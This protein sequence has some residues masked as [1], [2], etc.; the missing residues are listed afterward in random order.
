MKIYLPGPT[1]L[2]RDLKY[3]EVAFSGLILNRI[4]FFLIRSMLVLLMLFIVFRADALSSS[5]PSVMIKGKKYIPEGSQPE[6]ENFAEPVLVIKNPR[7]SVTLNTSSSSFSSSGEEIQFNIEVRNTG[8][9]DISQIAV[10]DLLTGFEETIALLSPRDLRNFSTS[11][12]TTQ[13]DLEAGGITN[14]VTA[15]GLDPENDEVSAD[16]TASVTAAS[17]PQMEP[18]LEVIKTASPVTYSTPGDVISFSIV[19][20][21]TGNVTLTDISVEDPLIGL[22]QIITTLDPESQ[23]E[24]TGNY[25]VTQADLNNGSITNTATASGTDAGNN[26]VDAEDS[27]TVTAV[28]DPEL[29][30]TKSASTATFSSVGERITYTITV[31]NT[32]NVTITNIAVDDPL[33][34]LSENIPSLTPGAVDEYTALYDVTQADL[35]KGNIINTVTVSGT[36]TENNPVTDDATVTVNAVFEPGLNVTNTASAATFSSVGETITYTISV[37]NTGNVTITN[38][39][40]SDL[41]TGLNENIVSLAPGADEDYTALYVV[42]QADLNNGTIV[43]TVTASG[44][45]PEN[46]TISETGTATVTAALNP[47]LTLTKT[48]S[49]EVFSSVGEVITYTIAVENTGNVTLTGIT[50]SDPLTGMNRTIASMAP[51]VKQEYTENYIVKQADL[52]QGSIV[53]K[54]TASGSDPENNTVTDDDE[55]TVNASLTPGLSLT[56][57]ASPSTFSSVGEDITYTIVVENTGNV[58][59]TG[60]TV[61]DP[62]TGMNNTIASLAPGEEQDY[63]E[64]YKVTQADLNTGSIVNTAT[65]SGKDPENNTVTDDDEVTINAS[66]TTGLSLTKSASPE[67]FSSVGEVITYSIVVENT[68]NVTISTITVSDPLTGMNRNIASLAPG[69]KADFTETYNITQADINSGSVTNTATASGQDPGGQTVNTTGSATVTAVLN[70]SLSIS[71]NASSESFSSAGDIITYTISVENTGNITLSNITVTDPLTAMNQTIATLAPGNVRIF[72]QTYT[73]T[74]ADVNEGSITNTAT[75][76]VGNITE[77]ASVTVTAEQNPQLNVSKSASPATFGTVGDEITFVIGVENTG[78]TTIS[79]IRVTDPM[80]GM[81]ETIG[82]L[83]PGASRNFTETYAVRQTD[84]DAGSISNTVTASSNTVSETATATATASQNPVLS[85]SKVASQESYSSVGEEISY[86]IIVLN[87]GNVTLTGIRVEDPLTGMNETINSLAPGASRTFNETFIVTAAVITAGKITNTVNVSGLAPDNS[88]VNAIAVAE[89]TALNPPVANDDASADHTSGDIV[90]VNILANDLLHDGSPA[91]PALVTVDIN[92][93]SPG[94]QDE[95]VVTGTGTWK[96]NPSTG[97]LTFTPV[98][99]FTTDPDPIEY[100]L[101]EKLTGLSDRAT[102]TVD[103]NEGEPFAINDNSSGHQPGSAVTINILANDRLSDGSQATTGTVSIDLNLQAEGIQTEF[104]R[105]GEGTWSYN[106]STGE[107][108]FVPQPGFTT[109]PTPLIYI[110]IENLTE[111][112]DQAIITLGYEEQ[113]PVAADDVSSGNNPGDSVSI[114]ILANDKLSDGT[115]VVPGLV[116]VDLNDAVSG[117]QN[118]LIVQG[119][120][121]WVYASGTG[122]LRFTP[123]SGFTVDPDPIQYRL[124]E[125][126]TGLGSNASVTILYNR[127]SPVATDDVSNGNKQGEIVTIPILANDRLSNGAEALPGLVTVDID[128]ETQ[129]IQAELEI[130]GEGIWTYNAVNGILTFTPEEGFS[131]NPSPLG[132]T[133]TENQTELSAGAQVFVNYNAEAPAAFDDTSTGNPQGEPVDVSILANDKMSDGSAATPGNVVV[134]L[135]PEADGIQVQLSVEGEGTWVYDAESGILTF[136][137]LTGFTGNPAPV[138]YSLCDTDDTTVCSEASVYV[139]YVQTIPEAAVALVKTGLYSI[140]EESVIY[141]FQ[142][143]NIGNVEIENISVSDERIGI[144]ALGILPS[145]LAPGDTGMATFTYELTADDLNA[146]MVTNSALVVGLTGEGE[147]VEDISGT[148][149]DNDDPTITTLDVNASIAVEK[150]TVFVVTE[151]V[152]NEVIDFRIIVTN[153]GNVV[154]TEVLVSDPLTGFEHEQEQIL[155]GEAFTFTTS[156]MVQAKDE[157]N[158]EFENIAYASGK[159]PDGTVVEDSSTVIIQVEGCALVIPNGFSPN[160]DGIQDYWRIQCIEKY[161]DAR[162][163]IFN[164]WGNRVFEMERFGNV[165]EHGATDAWWDGYSSSKATFGNGKLPAGTYYY[166]LDLGDGS[167]PLS[168]FIYLNR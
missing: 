109:D 24:F 10:S 82:S 52:N 133:L 64:V 164:R 136:T 147:R 93:Q 102:V 65:A 41:L 37:E 36:D 119:Q 92:L 99:G 88:T 110:L 104:I 142:V 69:N 114:D 89:V 39:A 122:M 40:V 16:D 47:E 83:A 87:T 165:E 3:D 33:G 76:T 25:P 149:A 8:N 49:S 134:D 101:T 63:T 159:A 74:Q 168:G 62:L 7:L 35:N 135:N 91:L 143:F 86:T 161:P 155:P 157:I 28:A 166:M 153:N 17:A 148:K 117:V 67:T 126:Y 106:T 124:I 140:E 137:P 2:T 50:V 71:K 48:A 111:Q 131:S 123:E 54:A 80:T 112:D 60:I 32:G 81:D 158:G 13:A 56:K 128:V 78:N 18:Q 108:T 42:K 19:V 156:Y 55:V 11:Y 70:Q 79:N 152:Q 85:V 57:S 84:L 129:G 77:T 96:Y 61:I 162:V 15:A 73:V 53:N 14:T 151:A 51:G 38:I 4:L 43:N 105:T 90:V 5:E 22:S 150:E 59:L 9:V 103:Y 46:N 163:E 120:G 95:L 58:T 139:Y 72:N 141:T 1:S 23:R 118:E 125:K 115:D 130:E 145:T 20:R 100:Q 45:D 144:S 146:G 94:I 26:Q 12:Y 68:G 34:G 116:Q 75:A 127:Q 138:K 21:N 97:G 113:P 30:V 27:E 6:S 29:S 31:E 121:R 44:K 154:L 132:Y 66:L 160:D 98:A 167:K 107:V